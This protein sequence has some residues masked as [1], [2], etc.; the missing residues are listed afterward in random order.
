[1]YMHGSDKSYFSQHLQVEKYNVTCAS[2]SFEAIINQAMYQM[3]PY[4]WEYARPVF[5]S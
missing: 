4:E 3:G 2:C 5:T 1:M